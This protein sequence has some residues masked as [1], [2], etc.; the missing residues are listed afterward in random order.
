V[1]EEVTCFLQLQRSREEV[2]LLIWEKSQALYYYAQ[3]VASI[4]SA[5][6]RCVQIAAEERRRVDEFQAVLELQPTGSQDE[7]GTALAIL[8]GVASLDVPNVAVAAIEMIAVAQQHE[9][10]AFLLQRKLRRLEDL[11]EKA[12]LVLQ[13]IR[14]V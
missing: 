11:L 8:R 3:Y 12:N 14:S 4:R 2:K 5:Y 10:K 9:A 7:K 13:K 1:S 6:Q